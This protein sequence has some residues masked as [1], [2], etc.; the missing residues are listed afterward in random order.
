MRS[1]ARTRLLTV[2]LAIFLVTSMATEAHAAA[3]REGGE[4]DF[5]ALRAR[6][7]ALRPGISQE[8]ADRI[9]ASRDKILDCVAGTPEPQDSRISI[10][11]DDVDY[12]YA[13]PSVSADDVSYCVYISEPLHRAL[14]EAEGRD[15]MAALF[16]RG[17]AHTA[18]GAHQR[19]VSERRR[20]QAEKRFAE[21]REALGK[22]TFPRFA[23]NLL[24]DY[25]DA[26]RNL[27][28]CAHYDAT[29]VQQGPSQSF[30]REL[31]NAYYTIYATELPGGR[32][33]IYLQNLRRGLTI[34]EA[35]DMLLAFQLDM[36]FTEEHRHELF[37]DDPVPPDFFAPLDPMK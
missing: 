1:S 26:S 30:A 7:Q 13:T 4:A 10:A 2:T 17:I 18:E 22:R 6:V 32:D 5:L 36:G 9:T 8:E 15:F 20:Q 24:G 11:L 25:K 31:F 35:K 14:T 23:R 34:E 12:M 33:C 37:G 21:L 28:D 29:V 19:A 16:M 3:A 27:A